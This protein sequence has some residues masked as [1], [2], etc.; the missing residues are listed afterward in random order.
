MNHELV[1][2]VTM[3][4]AAA[5]R[6]VLPAAVRRQGH[7]GRRAARVGALFLPDHAARGRAALVSRRQRRVR[8][9][10]DGRRHRPRAGRLRRDG[11]P[12]DGARQRALLR[13]ARRWC[14][15]APRSTS[16]SRSTR[17]STAR[18]SSRGWRAPTRPSRC[19]TGWRASR[20]AAATTPR[21]S[22][23][24]SAGRWKAPGP[25]G[26][27]PRRRSSRRTSRP[28]RQYPITPHRDLTTRALGSVSRAYYDPT[29]RPDLRR[30]Q[31]PR[32]RRARRRARREDR[33]GRAHRPAQGPDDL[34]RRLAGLRRARR[35][36]LLHDRQRRLPRPGPA[37]SADAARPRCCRRT[38]ASASSPSTGRPQSLWGIRH[39]NGLCTIVRMEA[40][41]T[42]WTR[43]VTFPYGTVVYDLDVSPDGT[44][45]VA[46]FG[47]IDG[48]MD[49]RVFPAEALL[50]GDTTA[51]RRFDF[52]HVGAVE[53]RLLAG[54]PLRLRHVVPH[55]RLQRL[56]L[57]AGHGR[58]RGG[59]QH[60]DRV[61][62]AD[63]ARRRRADRVPLHRA[64]TGARRAS[65]ARRSRTPRRSRF[66]A[67]GWPRKSR[68]CG[69]GSPGRRRTS[70]GR[71]CRRKT[72]STGWP[73]G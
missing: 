55:R 73:A 60:R 3:D 29:P 62:P 64:G 25:T 66:W 41:Y 57:R 13:S 1:H 20:A 5:A 22:A 38:R 45:V 4:Q 17:I 16:S 44:K 36:P 68:W 15:K 33:R 58:D 47:E 39:L 72:A 54:R 63:S 10:L 31:L 7:A 48:K 37:R 61:L 8:R 28:I 34:H 67:S 59:E 51:E 19:W 40:P 53:L 35:R 46:A 18:G 11:L 6:P 42:E 71:R 24:S 21:S 50:K 14:R 9:H 26:S 2:V 32:R 27:S 12:R 23:T 70:R 65:R 49:V 69:R 56:P 52:G 43:V 30:L